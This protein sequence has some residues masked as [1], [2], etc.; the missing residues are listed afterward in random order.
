MVGGIATRAEGALALCEGMID[1]MYNVVGGGMAAGAEGVLALCEGV[2][3]G[4]Y[5]ML[6]GRLRGMAAG[7]EGVLVLCASEG[8]IDRMYMVGGDLGLP[9][10]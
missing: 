10:W 2:I 4:M 5:D 7:A 1:G 6:G 8:V 9:A 3:D